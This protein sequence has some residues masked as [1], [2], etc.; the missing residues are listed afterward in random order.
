M[1]TP[2]ADSANPQYYT[3]ATLLTEEGY[4]LTK[5]K[6]TVS[7]NY[8]IY[9]SASASNTPINLRF[10]MISTTDLTTPSDV[11]ANNISTVTISSV[12]S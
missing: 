2:I 1:F 7:G 4:D 9:F 10:G 3:Y 12:T 6:M 8:C 5:F 11:T